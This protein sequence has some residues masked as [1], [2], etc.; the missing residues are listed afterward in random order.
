MPSCLQ[1][2]NKLAP[3]VLFSI[4]C[5]SLVAVLTVQS[6]AYFKQIT[7][8]ALHPN[9]GFIDTPGFVG[10][11]EMTA[12]PLLEFRP[13]AL[14]PLTGLVNQELLLRNEYLTAEN[15]V[16]RATCRRDSGWRMA[17]DPPG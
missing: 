14:N 5:G 3:A 12:Q 7:P 10:R 1:F 17:S 2:W 15:R 8:T 16:L 9:I 6:Q 4:G 11:L 13:I